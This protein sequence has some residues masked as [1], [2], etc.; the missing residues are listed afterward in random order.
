M[1]WF[2]VWICCLVPFDLRPMLGTCGVDFVGYTSQQLGYIKNI[3]FEAVEALE[4]GGWFHCRLTERPLF[5]P[6]EGATPNRPV[7]GCVSLPRVVGGSGVPSASVSRAPARRPL[8]HRFLGSVRSGVSLPGL[9]V[10][11]RHLSCWFLSTGKP[12]GGGHRVDCC[13]EWGGPPVYG[14]CFCVDL[15]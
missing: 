6:K 7:L 10:S 1:A 4:G 5:P 8:R 13:G 11:L 2:C 14:L 9:V 15:V 3:Y 12:C